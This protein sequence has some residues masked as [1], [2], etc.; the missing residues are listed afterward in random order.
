MSNNSQALVERFYYEVWN[1]AD[2]DVARAILTSDF[3]FRGSLGMEHNGPDGFITYMRSIHAALGDYQCIIE[4]II[5]GDNRV[6][7]KMC[8]RGIHR[9]PFLGVA[10]TGAEVQWAGAAFFT[11]REGKISALW[12][13][14]DIDGLK[15]QL[16]HAAAP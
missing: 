4:D 13:L 6:A 5:A 10:A 8:F 7:A 11:M 9:G 14:G 12:V 2:E 3:Q 16:A 1:Q 15:Q